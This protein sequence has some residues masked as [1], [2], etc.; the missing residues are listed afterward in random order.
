M[1]DRAAGRLMAVAAVVLIFGGGPASP[2]ARGESPQGRYFSKKRYEPH[3]LPAFAVAKGR[4]PSPVYD[5]NP[6][7]VQMYWKTWQLAFGNFHEPTPPSGFV[8]QFIDASFNE[9]IFLWDTCFLTMFCNY[10]HPWA[11]GIA[12]L[13]NFYAKQH[14]DGEICREIVRATGKDFAPWTAQ[15]RPI[16]A[17]AS[18]GYTVTYVNRAAP[19]PPP[20][21]TLDALNH[22]I[23]AWAELESVRV[24]GDRA[25]LKI[26]YEPLVRY[27]RALQKYLRQGNGLYM[28]DW[29]S[30]DNSPR[31]EFLAKG[32]TAVDTSSEM[33]LFAENL[34]T[35]ADLL[36]KKAD[37]DAFRREAADLARLVNRYMWNA[38]RRF[39]F[40][41]TW[42]GKQSPA[43]TIAAYWTLLAGVASTDQADALAA[44]LRNPKSF[45]RR[46]R[47]PT[48]PADQAGFD[49]AGGYWRGAVWAPTDTMVVRGLERCGRR[50]L[51]RQIALEHL[52]R[53]GEVF[54]NTGTVWENYAP[55]T[56]KPGTPAKADFVGWTGIVPILYF[57]EYAIGLKPDALN[58]R[59]TW[60]LGTEKRCGCERYR[61]N[62]HTVTLLAEPTATEPGVMRLVVDSD[63]DFQL[64]VRRGPRKFDYAV[65]KGKNVWTLRE[66]PL[67]SRCDGMSCTIFGARASRPP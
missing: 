8:S 46:H 9:N 34:A 30:M 59:L 24:T 61:F 66:S 37:A 63:G 22:P 25:R 23:M 19:Q 52:Q 38:D 67:H 65:K 56:V 33:V 5:E 39:Y 14:E 1:I 32:G 44:E 6:L 2:I 7:Y 62:G 42:D 13:D 36:H 55:D 64:C 29:A 26:V 41:L 17:S 54:K 60:V 58:N 16:L 28:T 3:P 43:K 35:I 49:P 50:E 21:L 4:L 10:G 51:A 47:V 18:G 40:D 20:C 57:L 31:N 27:Y 11:P 12:S 15:G 53:V 48:T 45:G